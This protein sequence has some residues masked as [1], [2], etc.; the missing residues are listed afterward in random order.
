[1]K[2]HSNAVNCIV[3]VALSDSAAA[4]ARYRATA[5]VTNASNRNALHGQVAGGDA[6]YFA[7][8]AGGIV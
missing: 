1:M 3:R 6:F 5:W 2:G 8:V 7:A 4:V